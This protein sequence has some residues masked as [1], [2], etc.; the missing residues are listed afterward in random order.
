MANPARLRLFRTTAFKL[1]AIYLAVFTIF[2]GF[3]IFY[4]AKN[5]G[6]IMTQQIRQTVNAEVKGLAGVYRNGG[7][8]RLT[9]AIE[10]LSR[11][12]GASLYLVTNRA[13]EFIAGR[14]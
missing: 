3:L 12:P 2:A 8:V 11:R 14:P 10:R 1:A 6:Q 9:R 4:I 5:T 7:I 13:G